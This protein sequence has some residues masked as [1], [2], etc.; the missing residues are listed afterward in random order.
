MK[1]IEYYAHKPGQII[2]ADK[3]SNCAH[4][5]LIPCQFEFGKKSY[6]DELREHEYIDWS[7]QLLS[8]H[9]VRVTHMY[10]PSC[11]KIIKIERSS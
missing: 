9:K 6:S 10:C 1:G 5:N 7:S 3:L 4:N 2:V 11:G 8:A